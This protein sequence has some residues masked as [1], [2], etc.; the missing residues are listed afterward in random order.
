MSPEK[1]EKVQEQA[2]MMREG[3]KTLNEISKN[4]GIAQSTISRYLKNAKPSPKISR[5]NIGVGESGEISIPC[6]PGYEVVLPFGTSFTMR[7]VQ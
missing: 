1:R 5:D 3:G 7:P 6:V 4:L 2:R